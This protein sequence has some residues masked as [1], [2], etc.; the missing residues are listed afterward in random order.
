MLQ[1]GDIPINAY[2]IVRTGASKYQ[3]SIQANAVTKREALLMAAVAAG[4]LLDPWL[5][6]VLP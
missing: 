6:P 1:A 4:A 2:F 5:K 3:E